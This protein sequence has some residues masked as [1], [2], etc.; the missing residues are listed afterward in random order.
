MSVFTTFRAVACVVVALSLGSVASAF[1]QSPD[2]GKAATQFWKPSDAVSAAER[3]RSRKIEALEGDEG[4]SDAADGVAPLLAKHPDS[5]V[6]ICMAGCGPQPSIVE[7]MSKAE[8]LNA[9]EIGEFEPNSADAAENANNGAVPA[10][11]AVVCIAGCNG[12][13]GEVLYKNSRL[14]WLGDENGEKLK[15]ALRVIAARLASNEEA[16]ASPVAQRR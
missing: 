11:G 5:S 14:T 15:A 12:K 13:R 8:S 9:G 3:E 7:V 6:I 2:A 4:I 10:E 1:A 16:A